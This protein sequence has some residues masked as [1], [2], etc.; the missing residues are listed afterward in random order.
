[1]YIVHFEPFPM[2]I[3]TQLLVKH[4]KENTQL[5]AAWI[6]DDAAR[7]DDLIAIFLQEEY[8]LVQ[9]AA[10]VLSE[11]GCVYPQLLEAYWTVLLHALEQP[12]HP[13]VQR[14]ILKVIADTG[15]RLP[16]VE[17]GRLVSACFDLI[18]N[19]NI[20]VAIQIHAMQCIANL[21]PI[22]PDLGVEL[23]VILEEGLVHGSAGYCS[24]ARKL[25]AQ[26]G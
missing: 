9:R 5:I 21:L 8:R 12:K 2:N 1:M 7:F 25:L 26:V 19:P 22:Y 10:W 11:V 23:K 13:A 15:I 14:N 16:E 18:A 4:S 6:G 3:R 20:P 17:E 24:R